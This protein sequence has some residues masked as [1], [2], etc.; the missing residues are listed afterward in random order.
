MRLSDRWNTIG[1]YGYNK[2]YMFDKN[3]DLMNNNCS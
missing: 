2:N 3:F 1:F